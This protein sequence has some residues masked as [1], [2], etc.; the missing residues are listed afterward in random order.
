MWDFPRLTWNLKY[1]RYKCPVGLQSCSSSFVIACFFVVGDRV[2]LSSPGCP[3]L[4][5]QPRRTLENASIFLR[6][7]P[8]CWDYVCV[9]PHLATSLFLSSPLT[10]EDIRGEFTLSR[11]TETNL[12]TKVII[13]LTTKKS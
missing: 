3:E 7:L 1:S 10:D 4:T 12:I 13:K 5:V 6:L 2:S 8:E 9:P 11:I